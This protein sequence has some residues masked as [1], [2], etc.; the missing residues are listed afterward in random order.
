MMVMVGVAEVTVAEVFVVGL[1]SNNF[2][3]AEQYTENAKKKI[4]PRNKAQKNTPV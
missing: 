1:S 3:S 4:K 2:S